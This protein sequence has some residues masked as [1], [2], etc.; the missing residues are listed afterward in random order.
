MVTVD[1]K[2]LASEDTTG[3]LRN[4]SQRLTSQRVTTQ[5]ITTS[6]L[7]AMRDVK[8][9]NLFDHIARAISEFWSGIG[10]AVS[11]VF[12]AKTA[13]KSFCELN[14]HSVKMVGGTVT[15]RCKYCDEEINSIDMLTSR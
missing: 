15:N 11:W 8:G 4:T 10:S 5:R 6:Q 2:S 13:K 7:K 9:P 1:D 3:S 12:A 14:G